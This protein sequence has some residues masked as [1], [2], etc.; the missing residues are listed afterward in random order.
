MPAAIFVLVQGMLMPFV[1]SMIGLCAGFLTL[2][3]H[4]RGQFERAAFGQVYATLL[5]GLVLTMNS[6]SI[7]FRMWL[8][9]KKKW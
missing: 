6:V 7:A 9:G 5:I 1:I 8:R 4:R 3:F 2:A